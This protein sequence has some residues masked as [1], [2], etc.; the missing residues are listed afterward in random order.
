MNMVKNRLFIVEGVPCTGKST[1]AEFLEDLLSKLGE[2]VVYY[3]EGSGNNPVDYEFHAFI[4]NEE[5]SEFSKVDKNILLKNSKEKLNGYVISLANIMG[6][7]FD[8]VIR[9]KIYDML[10]W[11]KEYPVMLEKWQEFSE[12]ASENNN[13]Y[14]LDCCML[15]NTL[16]EMM[17]RFNMKLE[18][19]KDYIDIIYESIRDL[20]PVIIYLKN[21]H[22][23]QRIIDVSKEREDTWLYE[24]I[25]YHTSQGYGK[26]H[27]YKGFN[28]YVEC[29]K[30][31]QQRELKILN[32][33]NMD[34][35]IIEN[36]FED[37]DNAH[38]K[39]KNFIVT[40]K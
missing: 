2:K 5:L 12:I 15:Q 36:P 13:I 4:T 17:M 33:L 31:R 10:P 30:A 16:C 11:E 22:I 35:I 14:V 23:R 18:L 37:W 39:I 38:E 1:T 8:K 24:V 25:E 6:D 9:Y 40:V 34:K 28:G 32:N 20:N 3:P 7:L 29:L 19:I 27:G 21:T 26:S